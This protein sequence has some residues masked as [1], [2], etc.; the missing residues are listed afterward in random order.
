MPK[1]GFG[2]FKKEFWGLSNEIRQGIGKELEGKMDFLF[3]KLAV[4]NTKESV[5]KTVEQVAIKP[6]LEDEISAC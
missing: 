6:N 2:E 5:D 3:D 4:Q 1:K